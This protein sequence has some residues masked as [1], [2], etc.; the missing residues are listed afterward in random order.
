MSGGKSSKLSLT[1]DS[2]EK[3]S[4]IV[5]FNSR[6]LEK[7]WNISSG[8]RRNH[9]VVTKSLTASCSSAQTLSIP[10]EPALLISFSHMHPHYFCVSNFCCCPLPA[11]EGGTSSITFP[12]CLQWALARCFPPAS[13][14]MLRCPWH[15]F[16]DA[17]SCVQ[18]SQHE[19]C[20]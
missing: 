6:N 3:S 16:L 7:S 12:H 20:E 19:L 4:S 17:G 10:W 11:A 14:Q 5:Y 9:P 13:E 15:A 2:E 1:R 18:G 8:S